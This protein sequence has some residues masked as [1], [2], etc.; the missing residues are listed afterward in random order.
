MGDSGNIIE[1]GTV[2]V[3]QVNFQVKSDL[4]PVNSTRKVMDEYQKLVEQ[5][6][7]R[8]ASCASVWGSIANDNR[9]PEECESLMK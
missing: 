3:N 9:S 6:L 4:Y 2:S 5:D 8:L 1:Q 7:T